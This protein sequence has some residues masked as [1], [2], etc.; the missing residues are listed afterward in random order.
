[1][2]KTLRWILIVLA[3]LIVIYTIGW[4][5]VAR[6]IDKRV[7]A[8]LEELRLGGYDPVCTNRTMVGFPLAMTM[9]CAATGA[10]PAT[11]RPW[12]AGGLAISAPFTDPGLFT[13]TLQSPLLVGEASRQ[14][15][16]TWSDM[17]TRLDMT[18]GGVVQE[19]AL[20]SDSVTIAAG[21][22]SALA[23][24]VRIVFVPDT[25]RPNDLNAVVTTDA[26]TATLPY[27]RTLAATDGVLRM[28]LE[29]GASDLFARRLPLRRGAGGWCA[30]SHRPAASGRRRRGHRPVRP[31]EPVSGRAAVGN[32]QRRPAEP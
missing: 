5:A 12:Q 15:E 18:L 26:A 9:T 21:P 2:P 13:A 6:S 24:A 27:G 11:G 3:G 25:D 8:G 20:A 31:V 1:M 23:D 29:D 14:A 22:H 30:D 19:I 28:S 4:F 17:D 7:A 16:V 10:S 32:R